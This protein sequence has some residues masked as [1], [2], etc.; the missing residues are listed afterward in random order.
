MSAEQWQIKP[1]NKTVQ[2]CCL[3]YGGSSF[4][5]PMRNALMCH[6][7]IL[8]QERPEWEAAPETKKHHDALLEVSKALLYDLAESHTEEKDADHYGDNPEDCLYCKHIK[9]AEALI[10]QAEKEGGL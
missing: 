1:D 8:R 3:A 9:Q 5:G 4:P 7:S 6:L 2:Q 10:A